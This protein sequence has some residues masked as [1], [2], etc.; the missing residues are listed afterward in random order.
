MEDENTYQ[1]ESCNSEDVTTE[2]SDGK[3]EKIVLKMRQLIYPK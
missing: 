3:V 2:S 1:T